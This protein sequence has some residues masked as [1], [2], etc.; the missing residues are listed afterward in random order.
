MRAETPSL[1]GKSL[2]GRVNYSLAAQYT[3]PGREKAP[4]SGKSR[5]S[6]PR[7]SL[8]GREKTPWSCKHG[9]VAQEALPGREKSPWSGKS[10]PGRVKHGLAAQDSLPGREKSPWWGKYSIAEESRDT[11]AGREKT[12]WSGKVQRGST[13]LSP[14][15]RQA[16]PV[17]ERRAVVRSTTYPRTLKE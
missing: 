2:P 10:L 7:V 13:I 17:E 12:A 15:W 1:V 4:W 11:H 8:P 5:R 16:H 6:S 3:L 14:T 9:V